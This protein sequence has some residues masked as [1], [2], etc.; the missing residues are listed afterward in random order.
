MYGNNALNQAPVGGQE[1][2]SEGLIIIHTETL[3]QLES[4]LTVADQLLRAVRGSQPAMLGDSASKTS[5]RTIFGDAKQM[6]GYAFDLG[7]KLSNLLGL[8]S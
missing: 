6:R 2:P 7:D 3:K 4:C 5:E 1:A 8:L